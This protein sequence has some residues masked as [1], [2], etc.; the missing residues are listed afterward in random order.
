MK[1]KTSDVWANDGFLCFLRRAALIQG[2]YTRVRRASCTDICVCYQ[3]HSQGL[4]FNANTRY[5]RG[6]AI[7]L[8]RLSC[9]NSTVIRVLTMGNLGSSQSLVNLVVKKRCRLCST[10]YKTRWFLNTVSLRASGGRS[11]ESIKP[12]QCFS[13]EWRNA[14]GYGR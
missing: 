11:D 4:S 7:R 13:W 2:H 1:G 3:T 14:T 12:Q 5:H 9:I 10:L 6:V 8:H